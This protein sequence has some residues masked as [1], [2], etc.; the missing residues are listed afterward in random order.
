MMTSQEEKE[1]MELRN[2]IAE[3]EENIDDRFRTLERTVRKLEEQTAAQAA[4]TAE[5]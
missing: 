1:L 3:L 2:R 5:E 4:T